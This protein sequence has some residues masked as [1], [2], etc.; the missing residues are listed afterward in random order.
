M[1][2]LLLG[3]ELTRDQRELAEVV[4]SSGDALLR[5]I[6]DI[7]DFS[8]IEA[9][10]FELEREPFDL[11]DCVEGALD[12]IAPRAA[13]KDVEL[14]CLIEAGVPAGIVGDAT[15][16]RQVLLNLLSN[17]VKFTEH[18]E[19]IVHVDAEPAGGGEH[20]VHLA[21]RDTGIGI[22]QARMDRLFESFSQVDASTSR[23]Y[24]GTG[25]G[26]AISKRIVELMGGTIWAESAEGAGSTF[27]IELAAPEASIPARARLEDAVPQLAAKRILVVD[28]SATNREIMT[29][30]LRSWGMEAVAVALPSEALT[31]IEAGEQFDLAALDMVM[32]EM[33]GFDLARE[34]RR[35]REGRELP[36][37]LLTSIADLPKARSAEEFSVQLAKPVRASQLY[38]A[39]VGVLTEQTGEPA[40]LEAAGDEGAAQWSSLRILLAE[41]N[42]VNQ[43]VA[44][45]LLDKLGYRADVALNGREALEALERQRYDV[46]LMD[47]QMPEMDGL[48]ASRR[49]CERWPA[50]SR[51]RIIAMT[52]NAMLEDREACFAAGMDDYL[53]KPVRPEELASAL[54]R[55]HAQD[56]GRF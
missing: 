55:A 46:V 21:V 11:R 36:L 13:E 44:L 56:R 30:Q 26:L 18:G 22:A 47:V 10:R 31:L 12:I 45:R 16:L 7:L 23:R 43:K 4:R 9:G 39:L 14:G 51:P 38:N 52:A 33:D 17:A 25:L 41:D 35:H 5:V 19:V 27:H 2:G 40:A 8:K 50:E 29:R 6:D 53:A 15:R 20:A 34:I 28:D 24:G 32:P 42:A 37:V 48:E 54:S 49:I 3:T 1:S